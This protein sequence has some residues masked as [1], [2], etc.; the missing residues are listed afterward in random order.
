[1]VGLRKQFFRRVDV[2]RGKER[3]DS[4]AGHA[5]SAVIQQ[6]H[7]DQLDVS[8][9]AEGRK[10]VHIASVRAELVIGSAYHRANVISR[11]Q[12]V[13]KLAPAHIAYADIRQRQTYLRAAFGKKLFPFVIG[14]YRI[15]AVGAV[16]KRGDGGACTV[17]RRQLNGFV[18]YGTVT[19]VH[20]VEVAES[21]RYGSVIRLS[22]FNHLHKRYPL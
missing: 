11:D 21:K 22:E 18:E 1:M 9:A 19:E 20:A 6:R 14:V 7:D 8:L 10:R 12:L 17:L 4:R 2:A 15:R 16:G 13:K 5:H 3:L